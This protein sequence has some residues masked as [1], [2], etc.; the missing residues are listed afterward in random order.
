MSHHPFWPSRSLKRDGGLAL[1]YRIRAEQQ[2]LGVASIAIS[3][4]TTHEDSIEEEKTKPLTTLYFIFLFLL[5]L[6]D[7]YFPSCL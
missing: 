7:L 5:F 1:I 3:D 2:E 4:H 6:L